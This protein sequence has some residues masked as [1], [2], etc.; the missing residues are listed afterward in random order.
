MTNLWLPPM[1][2]SDAMTKNVVSTLCGLWQ[3]NLGDPHAVRF[4]KIQIVDAA[5]IAR[6][7]MRQINARGKQDEI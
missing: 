3:G 1:N 7:P 5:R 6:E 2:A 4:R